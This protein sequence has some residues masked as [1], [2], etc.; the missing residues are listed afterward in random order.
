METIGAETYRL[1][2]FAWCI[3]V[4]SFEIKQLNTLKKLGMSTT[5]FIARFFIN[6]QM[7]DYIKIVRNTTE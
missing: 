2:K 1:Q 5:V 6:Y 4:K 7:A 3:A